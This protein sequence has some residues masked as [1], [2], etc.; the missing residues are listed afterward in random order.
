MRYAADFMVTDRQIYT[1]TH[2]HTDGTI[3]VTLQRMRQ[4]LIKAGNHTNLNQ[5]IEVSQEMDY[6]EWMAPH[7]PPLH[8]HLKAHQYK[9]VENEQQECVIL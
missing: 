7:T 2:T 3:T 8:D 9:F 1:H 5:V 4:G 6:K